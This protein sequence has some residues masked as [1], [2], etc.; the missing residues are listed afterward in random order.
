[1]RLALLW[2]LNHCH[3]F[4]QQENQWARDTFGD[5]LLNQMMWTASW[6]QF[7]QVWGRKILWKD[8]KGSLRSRWMTW[9]WTLS[10]FA[11]IPATAPAD[12]PLLLDTALSGSAGNKRIRHCRVQRASDKTVAQQESLFS[13]KACWVGHAFATHKR[14]VLQSWFCF[15]ILHHCFVMNVVIYEVM[16]VP[17]LLETRHLAVC[18]PATPNVMALTGMGE[19][20]FDVRR[21]FCP[22]TPP[23]KTPK[24]CLGSSQKR[25]GFNF[26][27]L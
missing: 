10:C 9:T 1:M 6:V 27:P 2:N 24:K 20:I 5:G 18:S 3:F 16:S 11:D 26:C 22:S 7:V 23:E 12:N 4:Y 15:A 17:W 14:S 25:H 13:S 21:T 8:R 19:G